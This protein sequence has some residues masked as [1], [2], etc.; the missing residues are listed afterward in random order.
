MYSQY[1]L[2]C[3]VEDVTY[4]ALAPTSYNTALDMPLEIIG[5]AVYQ[6]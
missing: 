6:I 4:Q 3:F 5:E 1:F 2:Y